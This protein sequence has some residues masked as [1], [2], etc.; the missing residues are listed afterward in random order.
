MKKIKLLI[1]G[2][3][4]QVSLVAQRNFDEIE[5]IT[6]Q[7]SDHIYMLEGGGGN[8][9]VFTGE[10]GTLMIDG[11]YAQLS[12]KIKTSIAGVSDKPVYYLVNTHWHGD[13]TGGNQNFANEGAIIVSHDNVRERLNFDQVRPF[14]GTTPAAPEI[15]WPVI[16]F[17]EKMQLHYND[18]SV[19]LIHVHSAHTDGDAFV[20]F[21]KANVLHM[22]DCF[23]KDR[24]PYVDL[25]S[26]GTPDG[27]IIAIE[28]ALLLADDDTKIIPG[29]GSL[30]EKKDLQK[31]LE[32]YLTMR[33]RV[34][35]AIEKELT[36]EQALEEK[37]TEGYE[38]LVWGFINEE[39]FVTML[40]NAYSE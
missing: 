12:E 36:V 21:P 22:G 19:Q 20:Y 3:L 24:F 34:K 29:H 5:I 26:G 17:D 40:F 8:I 7:V 28:A 2:V 31:C 10:D 13:H 6:H 35:E 23:F 14:R 33:D 32:M 39:K 1:L 11:Q 27:A 16:T 18:E 38:N 9:G 37:I 30:A 25:G 15:A 4:L